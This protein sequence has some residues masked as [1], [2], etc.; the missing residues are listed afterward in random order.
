MKGRVCALG[1]ILLTPPA[2]AQ[3]RQLKDLH[4]FAGLR[5]V[6]E[7]L[8]VKWKGSWYEL[9]KL[10]GRAWPE[11]RRDLVR[12]FGRGWHAKLLHEFPSVLAISGGH[13]R[14]SRA[15]LRD[16]DGGALHKLQRLT[17]TAKNGAAVLAA[18][19]AS[20]MPGP[21][22]LANAARVVGD[23]VQLRVGRRW[24]TI[25]SLAGQRID[26]LRRETQEY[27]RGPLVWAR[28]FVL[29][30]D[31]VM[32]HRTGRLLDNPVDLLLVDPETRKLLPAVRILRTEA[33]HRALAKYLDQHGIG[34]P[35][36][37][38]PDPAGLP[39]WQ[40]APFP[41]SLPVSDQRLGPAEL[42]AD[43]RHLHFLLSRRCHPE[44]R[45]AK[46]LGAALAKIR[47]AHPKGLAKPALARYLRWVLQEFCWDGCA[48]DRHVAMPPRGVLACALAM[49][50]ERVLV[51]DPLRLGLL[52]PE[53]PYLLALDGKPLAEWQALAVRRVGRGSPA[54]TLLQ[55]TT[56]LARIQALR[57]AAGRELTPEVRLTLGDG[58]GGQ[59]VKAVPVDDKR[60]WSRAATWFGVGEALSRDG[61]TIYLDGGSFVVQAKVA[62]DKLQKSLDELRGCQGLILDL[63]G[64]ATAEFGALGVLASCLTQEPLVLHVA[65][66]ALPDHAPLGQGE[67][68]LEHR[69]LYPASSTRWTGAER[70]LLATIQSALGPAAGDPRLLLHFATARVPAGIKPPQ[71]RAR[72]AVLIDAGTAGV[73]ESLVERLRV[74]PRVRVFGGQTAGRAGLVETHLLPHSLLRV[75]LPDTLLLRRDGQAIAGR[76]VAPDEA[77]VTRL[78]DI[79]LDR[80]PVRRAGAKWVGQ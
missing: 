1:L 4:I 20:P 35:P 80:D 13:F 64:L 43:L 17:A 57:A 28:W 40:D 30:P 53:H 19:P 10:N 60:V 50:G 15:T 58:Q 68:Y 72:V 71:L 63:R 33:R 61:G 73:V 69:G 78:A 45:R 25:W 7:G 79:E 47:A 39:A 44:A 16:K 36:E 5:H 11:L 32:M 14:W 55:Q 51:G 23:Q 21:R 76:G 42:A 31:D 54:G 67:G 9:V 77:V 38:G 56:E 70:E 24:L 65:G 34:A 74:L 59:R 6:G 66:H 37:P 22:A 12:S 26:A 75:H 29:D 8:E 52:D 18:A 41:W 62:P 49:D 46:G 27:H 48:M 2:W 3:A